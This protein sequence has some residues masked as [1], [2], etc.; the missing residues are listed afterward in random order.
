MSAYW[1]SSALIEAVQ[2]L[3]IRKVL[4]RSGGFTR[5]HTFAEV[6]ST[7]TGGRLGVRCLAEDAAKIAR[8][9]A[10]DLKFVELTGLE[11]LGALAAAREHGVRG[12]LVHDYLHAIAAQKAGSPVLY[13][14]NIGDFLSLRIPVT[15][16][17]PPR[18]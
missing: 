13:T 7:L 8:E 6:F 9:L 17:P 11:T 16:E 2:D 1:D 12:G 10:S 5:P 4:H 14:L 3:G 18:R 15:I